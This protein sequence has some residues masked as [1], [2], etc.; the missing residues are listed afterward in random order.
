MANITVIPE[1]FTFVTYDGARITE[2]TEKLANE[3]GFAPDTAITVDIDES[4]PL[5]RLH[6]ESIDPIVLKIEGG[7]IEESTA[8]RQLGERATADVIGRLLLRVRDR[9][10]PNFG[11]AP[12]D[13]KLDL[14]QQAAWDTYCVGR[15]NRL[16][17]D[18][19]EPRRR[20]IFRNR[21]GFSDI[22]DAVFQRLWTADGLTWA[23]L[24][25]ACA[26]TAASR[27]PA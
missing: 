8:P 10:D 23:D 20:Y 17:Y 5:G 18:V 14:A 25:A 1:T 7:A 21:H 24:E 6:V 22:A 15:L 26:E 3:L 11:E 9:R 4:T 16:G 27:Q 12:D 19:R 2:I 13:E